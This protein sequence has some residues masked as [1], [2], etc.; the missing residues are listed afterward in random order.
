MPR[1]WDTATRDIASNI[2]S[3]I[4]HEMSDIGSLNHDIYTIVVTIPISGSIFAK[5]PDIRHGK[6]PD[7]KLQVAGILNNCTIQHGNNRLLS[8]ERDPCDKWA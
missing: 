7:G 5:I 2:K 3:D 4:G 8:Y 6:D 1:Y